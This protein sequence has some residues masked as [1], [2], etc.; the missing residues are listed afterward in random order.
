MNRIIKYYNEMFTEVKKTDN[1]SFKLVD[2]FTNYGE[3]ISSQMY[4]RCEIKEDLVYLN[5]TSKFEFIENLRYELK[6]DSSIQYG[7]AIITPADTGVY[8]MYLSPT[9]DGMITNYVE[10]IKYPEK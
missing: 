5:P 2:K 3:F 8:I 9:M 4:E 10:F 7:I 6:H 1:W